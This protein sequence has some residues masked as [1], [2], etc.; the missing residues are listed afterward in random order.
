MTRPWSRNPWPPTHALC[1]I[2]G[3]LSRAQS[4][5]VVVKRSSRLR[6]E[7]LFQLSRDRN[8]TCL[9]MA[10]H[11]S[12]LGT[13]VPYRYLG[14]SSWARNRLRTLAL[15]AR[16]PDVTDLCPESLSSNGP[17]L[18]TS[19]QLLNLNRSRNHDVT[20]K[21]KHDTKRV[22]VICRNQSPTV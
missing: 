16:A 6:S 3:P 12:Q 14:G 8:A 4:T 1:D 18:P 19:A 9:H 20:G 13:P 5:R 10:D 17:L 7:E 15:G 22:N 11:P 2:S 21:C